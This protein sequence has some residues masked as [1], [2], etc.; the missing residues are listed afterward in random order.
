MMVIQRQAVAHGFGAVAD[1]GGAV[2]ESRMRVYRRLVV[3]VQNFK[4]VV[5][6]H[7]V[8][9]EGG[10]GRVVDVGEQAAVDGIACYGVIPGGACRLHDDGPE[11]AVDVGAVLT[12]AGVRHIGKQV[13][14]LFICLPGVADAAVGGGVWIEAHVGAVGG[15]HMVGKALH[16]NGRLT[17]QLVFK[18]DLDGVAHIGPDDQGA[19]LLIG[20][21]DRQFK[22]VPCFPL[23]ALGIL[24]QHIQQAVGVVVAEA[25]VDDGKGNG[26]DII[27]PELSGVGIVG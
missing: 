27:N 23:D 26:F 22:P 25:V 11:Q 14:A 15:Q 4:L 6:E 20:L 12:A 2:G 18:V 24:F 13:N 3:L 8:L 19:Y 21:R 9:P 17:V 10:L 1:G 5:E 7:S 16:V